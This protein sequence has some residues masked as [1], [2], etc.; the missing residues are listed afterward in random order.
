MLKQFQI[1]NVADKWSN[2][3]KWLALSLY[4]GTST[5]DVHLLR[6]TGL[7]IPVVEDG[8]AIP[9][10]SLALKVASELKVNQRVNHK[11]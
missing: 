8:L 1:A 6:K 5:R 4:M 3:Q 9:R 11:S 10:E 2:Y 7:I